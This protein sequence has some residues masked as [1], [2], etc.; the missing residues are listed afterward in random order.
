MTGSE[1]TDVCPPLHRQLDNRGRNR[2]HVDASSLKD[3]SRVDSEERLTY[4]LISACYLERCSTKLGGYGNLLGLP[5]WWLLICII[6]PQLAQGFCS[7]C[8]TCFR[9][10]K[11]ICL[12]VC[13]VSS[14][15]LD[16]SPVW[17]ESYLS[18]TKMILISGSCLAEFRHEPR[19]WR[20]IHSRAEAC[21]IFKSD[22]H[23]FFC[24]VD[25]PES[26]GRLCGARPS[27]S[28]PLFSL[29]NQMS[30]VPNVASKSNL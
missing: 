1:V 28:W 23:C 22:Q 12:A 18:Y 2:A 19:V 17:S 7:C 24:F 15:S 6:L 5:G 9:L 11:S 14:A 29:L 26:L 27:D 20:V 25:V 21:P 13:L 8:A 3:W 30:V 16:P 4:S 10:L